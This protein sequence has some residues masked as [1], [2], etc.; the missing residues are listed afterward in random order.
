MLI[1]PYKI[2]LSKK[3]IQKDG[4]WTSPKKFG[5][6]MVYIKQ[7]NFYLITMENT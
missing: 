4:S 2:I 1:A 5:F 7:T 6:N 3:D